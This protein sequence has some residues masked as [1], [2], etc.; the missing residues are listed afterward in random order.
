MQCA[1]LNYRCL[2][3]YS[4]VTFPRMHHQIKLKA[5]FKCA[6][7]KT[8]YFL[9]RFEKCC[10]VWKSCSGLNFLHAKVRKCFVGAHVAFEAVV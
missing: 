8:N 5:K 9:T 6:P 2:L 7:R 10:S 1:V 4:K 3:S